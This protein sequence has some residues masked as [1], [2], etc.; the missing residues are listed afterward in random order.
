MSAVSQDAPLL[1]ERV[2]GQPRVIAHRGASHEALENT[3]AAFR[4]AKIAGAHGVELDAMRCGSGEVVVFHDDDLKRLFGRRDRIDALPL[5]ALREHGI[6][7]L[8]EVLDELGPRMLVNVELKTERRRGDSELALAV[9]EILRR[10]GWGRRAL[11]SSFNPV[12]LWQFRRAAP[13][14]PSGLLF[15]RKQSL[16]LR[17]GW[18][19]WLLQ[20]FALHPEAGLVDAI[21]MAR[22]R[23][24]GF[25]VHVWTVDDPREIAALAALGVDGIITN[26]PARTLA[27]LR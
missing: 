17:E 2:H 19:A 21:A 9:A 6:P 22:W 10:G 3:I 14:M 12:A 24:G 7:T 26:E 13:E 25:A 1:W 11:V 5:A 4:A 18:P 27:A 16:P 8:E 15:H 20:P 23:R